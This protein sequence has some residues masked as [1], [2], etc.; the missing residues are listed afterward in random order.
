MTDAEGIET[1][2][3]LSSLTGSILT[4]GMALVISST[5]TGADRRHHRHLTTFGVGMATAFCA[6]P[7]F[8]GSQ[9]NAEVTG[10]LGEFR[11]SIKGAGRKA[12]GARL[13]EGRAPPVRCNPTGVSAI[14]AFLTVINAISI[15]MIG[16]RLAIRAGTMTISD[17]VWYLSMIAVILAHGHSAGKWHEMTEGRHRSHS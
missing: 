5:S 6:A 10:R 12:R 16:R 3:G 14:S 13:R 17:F 1:G 15:A 2:H 7:A 8:Q 4:A 11:R 9:I